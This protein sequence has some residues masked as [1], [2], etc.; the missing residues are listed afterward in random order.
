MTP[1]ALAQ[2]HSKA[3]RETRAW[4]ETEFSALLGQKGVQLHGDT[5][6]IVLTRV[7]A[8]EAEILTLATDP[9]FRRKGLARDALADAEADCVNAGATRMFLEVAENNAAA[10]ALYSGAGYGQ[11]GYRPGYYLPKD[12]APIG[13]CV[14][15]KDI[16][17]R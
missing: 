6:C 7:I 14:L 11:V 5:H 12:G 2:L 15:S 10:L 17:A 1:A 9:A 3:F 4:T 13:A 16:G 8:D